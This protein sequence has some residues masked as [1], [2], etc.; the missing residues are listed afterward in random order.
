MKN[1]VVIGAGTM[2]NGI[3]H[4]FAQSGFQVSLVDVKQENLDKA[5][6][7][8]TTNLDRIIAKGNLTEE[9]KSSTLGNITTFTDLKDAAPNANL[10]VEAAT[11]NLELKLKIF[12][13]IDELAPE[14]CILATNTSS[15]SITQIAAATK[16]PEKVIGMHFMNP[17]PIMKLVEIIKGYS[18]S[19]DTFD[20]IFE[21]S[22]NLGKV[23][24]EVNDYPGFVANR[25]LMP[26]INE[27]IETLY[28][29]VAGVE[30]IDTVMKLGMAHPMGPLQ[31]ADFIGLD[32]CLAILNVMYDGFKN[33]KYAPN[34]LLVNMVMAGKKGVKSGEGFYDYSESKK[35]EKVSKMFL[36]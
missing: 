8:I 10:I 28:N 7:T 27:A 12:A 17:V 4:T 21:M 18:T 32:V 3:A 34:P 29:G 5:L 25:I 15:I 31:L 23:P 16:R 22:K 35:A 24:V 26:M 36:K 9:E 1:I 14:S 33:P 20:T 6:K 2:G 11:E 30:E 19:K 13:Q